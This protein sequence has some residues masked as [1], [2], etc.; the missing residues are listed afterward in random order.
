MNSMR[1]GYSKRLSDQGGNNKKPT[2]WQ[3]FL[4]DEHNVKQF[5]HEAKRVV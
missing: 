4:T 5:I 3:S 1:L 2:H